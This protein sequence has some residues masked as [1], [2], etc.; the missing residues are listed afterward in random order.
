MCG[1][2]MPRFNWGRASHA[3]GGDMKRATIAA[4][5]GGAVVACS[6]G[7]AMGQTGAALG[8]AE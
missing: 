4:V 1:R 6:A 3:E 5:L 7:A 2:E 8:K